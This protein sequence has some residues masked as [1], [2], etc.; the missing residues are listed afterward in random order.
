MGSPEQVLGISDI[1]NAFSSF[2][3]VEVEGGIQ[4]EGMGFL[5][6]RTSAPLDLLKGDRIELPYLAEL[7]FGRDLP[8]PQKTRKALAMTGFTSISFGSK[9][10]APDQPA[11]RLF[12]EDVA[13][14]AAKTS[15]Q[16]HV[17]LRVRCPFPSLA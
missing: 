10:V 9:R 1:M 13:T 4:D 6:L 2:D 7:L 12:V 5:L 16:H 3:N 8:V 15:F 17:W 11:A 14:L